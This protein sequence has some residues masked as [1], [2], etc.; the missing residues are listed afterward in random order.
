MLDKIFDI[1]F[2]IPVVSTAIV[3]FTMLSSVL[4]GILCLVMGSDSVLRFS[5]KY[6]VWGDVPAFNATFVSFFLFICS[7]MLH[8]FEL[9]SSIYIVNFYSIFSMCCLWYMIYSI[10]VWYTNY[11][12]YKH[13]K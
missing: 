5:S 4:I 6:F 7:L 11:V 9:L 1:L 12:E 8:E 2:L 3:V 10:D 13:K